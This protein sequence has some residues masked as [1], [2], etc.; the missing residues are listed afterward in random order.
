MFL[1]DNGYKKLNKEKTS[2]IVRKRLVK[3]NK[4]VILHMKTTVLINIDMNK[5]LYKVSKKK[6]SNTW[7]LSV[8][9]TVFK[10]KGPNS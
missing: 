5:K 7:K 10:Q 6:C 9:K 4:D 2:K 1:I 8:T 3:R